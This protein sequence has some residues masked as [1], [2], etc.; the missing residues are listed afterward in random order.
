M[1]RPIALRFSEEEIALIDA[2]GKTL[3]RRNGIVFSRP[4][5]VRWLLHRAAP[6]DGADN[7]EHRAAWRAV[8]GGES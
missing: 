8:F 5:V 7:A 2:L 1:K 6:G 3:S 4:D